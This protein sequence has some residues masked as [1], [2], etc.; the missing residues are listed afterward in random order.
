MALLD[1]VE[2]VLGLLGGAAGNGAAEALVPHGHLFDHLLLVHHGGRL[3]YS[4]E[5][6]NTFQSVQ[7]QR[8]R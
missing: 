7:S 3:A 2:K 6:A 5:S 1:D 4:G 8:R